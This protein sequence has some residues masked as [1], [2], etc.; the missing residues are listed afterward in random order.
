MRR[1]DCPPDLNSVVA[2]EET[3]GRKGK[4]DKRHCERQIAR[5]GET[6]FKRQQGA[7]ERFQGWGTGSEGGSSKA[8][9]GAFAHVRI[10]PVVCALRA[11]FV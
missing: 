10:H 9:L 3:P 6:R 2:E 1:S 7:G 5:E 8:C 4:E 11:S